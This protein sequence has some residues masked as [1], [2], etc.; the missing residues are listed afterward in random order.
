[1]EF[2][3]D[4]ARRVEAYLERN[5]GDPAGER[6]ADVDPLGNVHLTQFWQGY[7]LGNVRDRSFGDIWTD[8]TNPL[9][10]ALRR[11]EELLTGRCATC[12]YRHV[13]RGGSRLRA[14]T[15]AEDLFA[16]DPQCY[17]TDGEVSPDAVPN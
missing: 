11:R 10:G 5:G 6:I 16:P 2:G 9:V 3:A 14:L 13:C 7:S 12:R 17:L 1:S 15:V 4:H 8:E